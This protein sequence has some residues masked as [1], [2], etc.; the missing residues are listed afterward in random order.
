MSLNVPLNLCYDVGVKKRRVKQ[1]FFRKVHLPF[2]PSRQFYNSE[3]SVIR[4]GALFVGGERVDRK[5]VLPNAA[6]ESNAQSCPQERQV[7]LRR[8]QTIWEA[9]SGDNR[10]P[11]KALRRISGTGSRTEQPCIT[12]CKLPQH[13]A[14]RKGRQKEIGL[15]GGNSDS[16]TTSGKP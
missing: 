13:Q 10:S 16:Y 11:Y 3:H 4:L 12:V 15:Y 14:S 7:P 8:L 1:S 2:F 9:H 6:V 5:G